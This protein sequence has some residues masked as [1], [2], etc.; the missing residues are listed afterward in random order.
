MST[1]SLIRWRKRCLFFLNSS[2][3][4]AVQ[5]VFV[6]ES[7]FDLSC[8]KAPRRVSNFSSN[9]RFCCCRW[10]D[11]WTELSSFNRCSFKRLSTAYL[12]LASLLG[13]TLHLLFFHGH[14][15]YSRSNDLWKNPRLL[16]LEH[17]DLFLCLER[18]RQQK[19]CT[20]MLPAS[21]YIKTVGLFLHNE[22]K[23]DL[24]SFS[25]REHP[26]ENVFCPQASFTSSSFVFSSKKVQYF[27]SSIFN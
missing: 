2:V 13:R 1:V 8:A 27:L 9:E 22:N 5:S 26:H 21:A 14:F 15:L 6:Q 20:F 18:S 23:G 4:S 7:W 10:K 3:L 17:K 16:L 24:V 19:K 11:A 25:R 12:F